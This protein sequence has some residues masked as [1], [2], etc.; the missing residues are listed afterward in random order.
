MNVALVMIVVGVLAGASAGV[1]SSR[2]SVP[3]LGDPHLR[4]NTVRRVLSDHPLARRAARAVPRVAGAALAEA[5]VIAAVVVIACAAVVGLILV[6]IR[7]N[8]GLTRADAPVSQWAAEHATTGSTAVMSELSKFGGT[9][10][11]LIGAVA[12]TVYAGYR[13]RRWAVPIF[14]VV[15]MVGQFAVSNAIK[16]SVERARPSLS[17]LTGFS[18]TSFPSGHAV[19]AAAAWASAAFLLG[20]GRS[21]HVRGVLFGV[22]VGLG[23]TVAGT[24]VALGVHWTT[25][26]IAGLMIGWSWFAVCA[27]LF[28]GRRL[29]PAEPLL[30]AREQTQADAVAVC[31]DRPVQ[32][33]AELRDRVADG[34]IT[35]TFRRWSRLQVRVG[36]RYRSG[37]AMIEIDDIDLVPFSSIDDDDLALTGEADREALRRRTA[38]AGPVEDD[39]LVYRI[40]FHVVTPHS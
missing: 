39:T 1:V 17:N 5:V 11:V 37:G 25:D 9:A 7:S 31:E 20:R 18:G 30:V 12:V 35:L 38:H 14:V 8:V 13:D 19:A 4:R 24:R 32:F 36:G 16:W 3:D 27:V 22:A 23:V 29:R 33:S 21:R 34:T 6:M 26:V 40:E 10:Y 2:S 15:A 28:G